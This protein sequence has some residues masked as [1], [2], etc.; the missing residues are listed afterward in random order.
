MAKA[1]VWMNLASM[2][3]VTGVVLMRWGWGGP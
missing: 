2:I 1:G 3:V